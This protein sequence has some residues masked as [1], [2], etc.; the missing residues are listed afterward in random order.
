MEDKKKNKKILLIV[1]VVILVALCIIIA[2]QGGVK[3]ALRKAGVKAGLIKEKVEIADYSNEK[4]EFAEYINY[5]VFSDQSSHVRLEITEIL[6][7]GTDVIMK[8]HYSGLDAVGKEWV[9]SKSKTS[10]G[11]NASSQDPLLINSLVMLKPVVEDI[12]NERGELI[13]QAPYGCDEV[14]NVGYENR[15][16]TFLEAEEGELSCLAYMRNDYYNENGTAIIVDYMMCDDAGENTE[17]STTIIVEKTIPFVSYRITQDNSDMLFNLE[18]FA[19]SGLSI[20][21]SGYIDGYSG[22][23]ESEKSTNFDSVTIIYD[24]G[25]EKVLDRVCKSTQPDENGKV[26]FQFTASAIKSIKKIEGA[27]LDGIASIVFKKGRDKEYRFRVL[28]R[29]N[30]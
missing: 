4:S 28:G 7:D 30:P 9:K 17:K 16:P 6:T 29:E 24:D 27:D 10:K 14:A 25:T 18:R 12:Y 26:E 19:F 8:V 15:N 21:G 13:G 23:V 3:K 5:D 20:L 1:P 2:K 11:D 22:D